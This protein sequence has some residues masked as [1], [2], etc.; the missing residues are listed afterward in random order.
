MSNISIIYFSGAGHTAKLA[1]AISKGA[2]SVAGVKTNLIPI[3]GNDIINGRYENNAIISA[4]DASD[5]II[6]GSPTYMGGPAAQF[7]AF[8]DA[9]VDSWFGQKWRDKPAAGFTVS[10]TPSGDKFST[11][12]YFHTLAMEHGMIWVG[13]GEMP[14]QPNGVN[15]LGSWGGA[16]GQAHQ[17][18]TDIA[19]NEDDKLTGEVLGKRVAEFAVKMKAS[20]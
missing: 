12:Q 15:R 18:P 11:L 2:I 19:P 20:S 10:G 9:T 7:K 5:A 4:L 17:E 13:L 14:M 1:E 3:D 16:M 6:F 8:A